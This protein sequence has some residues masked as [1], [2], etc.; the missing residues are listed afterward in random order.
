MV[1]RNKQRNCDIADAIISGVINF[2]IFY[3]FISLYNTFVNNEPII[4]GP[5]ALVSVFAVVC[6]YF[7]SNGYYSV[8]N[9]IRKYKDENTY[10]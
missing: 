1:V 6:I 3:S 4:S 5:R 8:L 7:L 9:K 10:K 2:V